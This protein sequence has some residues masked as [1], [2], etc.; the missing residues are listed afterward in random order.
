MF[1]TAEL[2]RTLNMLLLLIIDLQKGKW[3]M[4]LYPNTVWKGQAREEST[5]RIAIEKPLVVFCGSAVENFE[6]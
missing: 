3:N 6:P 5:I 1:Q 2:S 4:H